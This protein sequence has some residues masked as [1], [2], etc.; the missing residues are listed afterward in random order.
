MI[1]VI[2]YR[3]SEKKKAYT[4]A[5]VCTDFSFIVKQDQAR[6]RYPTIKY[7]SSLTVDLTSQPEDLF[8]E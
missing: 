4:Y 7:Q 8:A 2:L 3:K 1:S 5:K 6:H